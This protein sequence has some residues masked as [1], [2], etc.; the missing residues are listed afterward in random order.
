MGRRSLKDSD[1]RQCI[2]EYGA[3]RIGER[4]GQ[5]RKIFEK[6][7]TKCKTKGPDTFPTWNFWQRNVNSK[8]LHSA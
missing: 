3:F 7:K 6:L 2:Q 5:F 8:P 4:E 1:V